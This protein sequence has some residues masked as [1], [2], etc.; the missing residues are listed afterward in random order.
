MIFVA[1]GTTG[2]DRLVR[3]MDQLAPRLAHPVVMQIGSGSYVPEQSTYFR[4]AASVDAQRRVP[5]EP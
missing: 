5:A 1:T 2:F 3:E 4:L